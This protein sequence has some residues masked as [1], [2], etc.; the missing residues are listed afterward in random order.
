MYLVDR[1][2]KRKT[3]TQLIIHIHCFII[4]WLVCNILFALLVSLDLFPCYHRVLLA[5]FYLYLMYRAITWLV[6]G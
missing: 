4:G 1:G 6:L 3:L 5:I 2:L